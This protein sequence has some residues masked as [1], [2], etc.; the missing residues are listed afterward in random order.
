MIVTTINVHCD[1]DFSNQINDFS[2]MGYSPIWETF[3]VI[4]IKKTYDDNEVRYIIV[5]KKGEE[6]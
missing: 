3:K 4:Y 5:M 2:K 6:K 1:R